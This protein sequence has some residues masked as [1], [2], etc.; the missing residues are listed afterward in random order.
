MTTEASLCSVVKQYF[1]ATEVLPETHFERD[2]DA[3]WLD[4]LGLF[5]RVEDEFSVKIAENDF[6]SL[7]TVEQLTAYV[8]K[9]L[10]LQ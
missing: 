7:E 8:K 1:E 6:T 2:L 5:M 3:C 10:I 9:Q 4:L